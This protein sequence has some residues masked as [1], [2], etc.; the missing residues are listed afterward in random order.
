MKTRTA[1]YSTQSR[2]GCGFFFFFF[3]SSWG[4]IIIH[5]FTTAAPVVKVATPHR[6]IPDGKIRDFLILS[7]STG[8][9]YY[10]QVR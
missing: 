4:Q 10:W 5:H 2:I 3:L 1:A 7:I 8:N 6:G 9:L